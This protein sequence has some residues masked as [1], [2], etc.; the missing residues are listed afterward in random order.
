[1]KC[2]MK[3]FLVLFGSAWLPL[4]AQS[5]TPITLDEAVREAIAGNR[6]LAAARLDI[7]VA[8]AR[9]IT[10]RLRPNPVVTFSGDH[11]DLLG[12]GYNS[13]NN[14]GPNEF[15]NRIDFI[16]ER[17]GKR[18]ARMDVAALGKSV[19]EL[20]VEEAIRRLMFEVESAFVDV[21]LAKENLGLSQDNLRSLNGI[22]AVNTERVRTGDL[23]AVELGRSQVA[24]MQS[25][26]AVRQAELQLRQA[27]NRLRLL[28]GRPELLNDFDV[29][30][31][32][33]RD[34]RRIELEDIRARA[35]ARRPDLL[36]ARRVLARNQADMKLQLAQGKIDYTT[37]L[38]YRRQQA[39]SGTGNSLGFFFSMPLPVFNRNQGEIARADREIAQAAAQIR[40][41]E[42][43]LNGEITSAWQQYST[44][45][46]LLEDIEQRMLTKARDVRQA[47]EYSYRRGE[48]SLVEFLDA[49]R[50]FNDVM[51]NYNEARANYARS[52]YYID[53]VTASGA[54]EKGE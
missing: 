43:R 8:E 48:A 13:V 16:L 20:G 49:Q 30:G 42:A 7:S 31:A 47:T 6:D 5:S 45:R 34:V 54:G 32:I 12:T 29:A 22:V 36:E 24:A 26:T 46:G 50:A 53:S 21:Q 51:Q 39:A 37:G 1:M 23:A 25:Q 14:G 44:S 4:M 33:R 18:A 41:L 9:E 40:A 38:E 19:A 52:L 11:L 10:A 3:R 27:R 28:L 17:G 35:F 15:S 2:F